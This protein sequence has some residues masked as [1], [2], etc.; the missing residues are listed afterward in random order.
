MREKRELSRAEV[1]RRRRAQ[2]AANELTQTGKRATTPIIQH[3]VTRRATP[4]VQKTTFVQVQK[5]RKF[6]IALGF[7]DF[8]LKRPASSAQSQDRRWRFASLAI[9]IIFGFMIL[10]ALIH[11]YF[12]IPSV[13]VIGNNRLSRE[14]ISNAA[15]VLGQSIFTVQPEDVETQLRISYPELLSVHANVYLPNHVYV[16]V[17]E[18][19]P[20]I[21]W[22]QNGAYT[23]IDANG[24]AFRP[25]G[26]LEGL[27]PVNGLANPKPGISDNPLTPPPYMQKDLAEAIVLLAPSVP[28]DTT[29]FYDGT[30]GLGWQD[31]RGWKVFFGTGARDMPLKVRVY[32]SLAQSLTERLV[33]PVFI[34]VAYPEAPYYRMAAE[35]QSIPV[36]KNDGQ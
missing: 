17:E 30:Y 19:Q 26:V 25:H 35:V 12:N 28:A 20:V 29:M 10:A 15:G 8:H 2:R 16:M 7:P 4:P 9:A 34:N 33:T 18:R 24:V 21:L 27:V 13:T 14:E 31:S 22:Q 1:A 5:K 32:E 11:P 23:W 3:V 36:I 6:N